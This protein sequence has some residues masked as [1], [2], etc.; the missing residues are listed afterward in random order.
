AHDIDEENRRRLEERLVLQ[1]R[2]IAKG[3]YYWFRREQEKQNDTD[4]DL[5]E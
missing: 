4:P 2:M 3:A 5:T 1:L